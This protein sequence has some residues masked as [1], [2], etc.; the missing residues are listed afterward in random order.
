VLAVTQDACNTIN[1]LTQ[2]SELGDDAGLR[3]AVSAEPETVGQLAAALAPSP[4]AEDQVLEAE[5]AHVFLDPGA[6]E[7]LDDKVLDVSADEQGG[8]QFAI[9]EQPG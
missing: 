9:A 1:G 8:L 6:A 7:A 3:I 5:G 4:Q 2:Q